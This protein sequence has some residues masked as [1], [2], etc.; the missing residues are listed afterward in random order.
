[1]LYVV[2]TPIGNLEDLSPRAARVLREVELIAAEDTRSARKL[3]AH[4]GIP[5]PELVSMFEGN[6][7]ERASALV[8]ELAS[9]RSIALISEAGTPVISDPGQRLVR[10]AADAGARVE[11]VPGPSAVITALVAS[12]LPADAF[13][14]LGFPPREAGPRREAFGALRRHPAT[15]V[16]YEAPARVAATL[17]DLADALGAARPAALAR[18]LTKLHEEIVRGT[19]GELHARFAASAPRGECTLVIAGSAGDPAEDEDPGDLEARVKAL[20]DQGLGPRDVAARLVA[21]T[22]KPRRALYQLALSIQRT[23][24]RAR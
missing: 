21:V 20:L 9:G 10:A 4:L 19:L 16:L 11:V 22:G 23:R 1:V 24:D 8:S 3:L 13:T 17:S 15:L 18:E 6:E 14:F 12:G 7:V 5:T 2:A